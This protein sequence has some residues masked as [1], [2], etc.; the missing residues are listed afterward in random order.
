M[1][2]LLNRKC[3][4]TASTAYDPF[5]I[6]S[7]FFKGKP[8]TSTEEG[9]KLIT[10]TH[11][12]FVFILEKVKCLQLPYSYRVMDKLPAFVANEIKIHF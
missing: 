8:L 2:L 1:S 12:I 9:V 5:Q 4:I 7:H 11:E 10:G 6:F 3:T